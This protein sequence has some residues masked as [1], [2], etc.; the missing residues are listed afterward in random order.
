M[1]KLHSKGCVDLNQNDLRVIKTKRALSSSL[2]SL[3]EEQV[4]SSIT[5]NMICEKALVHRTTF[6]KHFYDKY[7]L[8]TY[9]MHTVTKDYFDKDIRERIEKPFQSL[10]TF[11]NYPLEKI[12]NKQQYDP[13]F[14]ETVITI[15]IQKLRKDIE[16]NAEHLK[17]EGDVPIEAVARVFE[18]TL[19][20]LAKWDSESMCKPSNNEKSLAHLKRLDEIF[21]K[22]VNIQIK[23]T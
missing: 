1:Y 16:D 14:F 12:D 18:A 3:L 21:N 7:D 9:Y 17:I 11:I 5:V 23:N 8:L 19:L 2:A 13:E 4:F 15:F 20:S 6:Y 10:S 22:L